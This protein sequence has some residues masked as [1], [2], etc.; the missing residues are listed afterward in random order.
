MTRLAEALLEF[1]TLDAVQIRRVIA[2]LSLEG[3]DSTDAGKNAA[4]T[5]QAG[6][7]KKSLLPP[8]TGNNPVTA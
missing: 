8:M 5:E 3:T 7:E 2:G 6:K 1:E 4:D